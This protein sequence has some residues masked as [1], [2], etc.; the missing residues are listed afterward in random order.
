M[1][2]QELIL[3]ML[4]SLGYITYTDITQRFISNKL[5]LVVLGLSLLCT[6]FSAFEVLPILI[7]TIAGLTLFAIGAFAGGDIKLML[8]LLPGIA[9]QWWPVVFL[10][11]TVIGGLM[12]LGYL[13]Y[14]VWTKKLSAVRERGLPYGVPIAIAGFFGVFLTSV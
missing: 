8:A 2:N 1:S 14:G 13:G 4:L 7:A 5:V 6:G 10:L 11:I 3:L 12:A 9:V